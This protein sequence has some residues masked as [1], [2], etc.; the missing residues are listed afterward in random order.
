MAEDGDVAGVAAEVGD[1]LLDPGEGGDDVLQAE[2][3]GFG[4]PAAPAISIMVGPS[5]RV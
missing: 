4:E 5:G 3:A 2:V 1:V